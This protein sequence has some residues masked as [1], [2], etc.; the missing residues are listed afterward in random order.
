[1]GPAPPQ[2]KRFLLGQLAARGD[3]LYATAVARQIKA[4]YPDC[5][6]TWAIGSLCRP[7]LDGN[8]HVDAV[9]EVP[10]ADHAGVAAAWHGFYAE[11]RRRVDAGEFDAA[12]FTQIYPANFRHYDGTVRASIFRGYPRPITV[13]VAPVVRLSESEIENVRRFAQSHDLANHH[14]VILFECIHS[15]AQSF[16]GPDFVYRAID[17]LVAKLPR[18]KIILSSHLALDTGHPSAISGDTLSFRENAELT[19][20]CSLLIGCSSGI[21]WLCTSDWARPLPTIQLLRQDTGVYAS[22]AHD[23]DHFGLPSA[24]V[25]E[26]TDCPAEH[27]VDCVVT[28]VDEGVAAARRRFHQ[29][30]PLR[31]D[32]YKPTLDFLVDSDAGRDAL[33]SCALILRRYGPR[34]AAL[35]LALRTLWR[36]V[37]ARI[38]PLRGRR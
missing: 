20:Y 15:S 24:H 37:R 30:L 22:V 23:H 32:F 12:F 1:M 8:P 7:L 17:L 21:T 11:A 36:I 29:A 34:P 3:C 10:L 26:L 28:T 18:C 31:F 2:P 38:D 35:A 6:L 33:H 19:K 16:I 9:W 14:P 13:P 27:L 25:I 4:D 5:H